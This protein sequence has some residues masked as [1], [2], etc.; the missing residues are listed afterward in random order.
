MGVPPSPYMR[1]E[2]AFNFLSL[3]SHERAVAKSKETREAFLKSVFLR[4]GEQ[5]E[6]GCDASLGFTSVQAREEHKSSGQK[7]LAAGRASSAPTEVCGGTGWGWWE[8]G[9]G[10]GR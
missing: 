5:G 1:A 4:P 10:W 2:R 7:G 3:L 6:A 8:C 9:G